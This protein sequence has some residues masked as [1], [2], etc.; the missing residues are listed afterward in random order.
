M[1]R[2][3]LGSITHYDAP[4]E[5]TEPPKLLL[6]VRHPPELAD[7]SLNLFRTLVNGALPVR[8]RKLATLAIAAELENGTSGATTRAAR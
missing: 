6:A 8:D 2:V 5:N 3:P 1:P 4:D 7:A